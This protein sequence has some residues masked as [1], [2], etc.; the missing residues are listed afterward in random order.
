MTF[1][2][3]LSNSERTSETL[4]R[5]LWMALDFECW[6]HRRRTGELAKI[7]QLCQWHDSSTILVC[8]CVR[9][10][11]VYMY[12]VCILHWCARVFTVYCTVGS[13]DDHTHH[14]IMNVRSKPGYIS[15]ARWWYCLGRPLVL[16]AFLN[17]KFFER[18]SFTESCSKTLLVEVAV[19]TLLGPGLY[20]NF[21][22]LTQIF[23]DLR[24]K[25]DMLAWFLSKIN[26]KA[27][28]IE[29]GTS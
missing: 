25:S 24:Y 3:L 4:M 10:Q 5:C 1:P 11:Y 16:S 29:S 22:I 9:V 13:F 20:K 27:V 17:V 28:L 14:G 6:P 21:L 8:T 2:E 12:T 15:V 23:S 19:L 26:K 18:P 7:L